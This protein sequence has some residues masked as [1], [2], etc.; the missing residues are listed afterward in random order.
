MPQWWVEFDDKLNWLFTNRFSVTRYMKGKRMG[1]TEILRRIWLFSANKTKSSESFSK[2]PTHSR[3]QLIIAAHNCHKS[4]FYRAAV[5]K[6]SC[7][8]LTLRGCAWAVKKIKVNH[9]N[10]LIWSTS[11]FLL[12]DIIRYFFRSSYK[13]V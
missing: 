11:K 3:T 12:P 7:D 9:L 5:M 6:V 13:L 4:M 1:I 10:K 2:Q 8:N